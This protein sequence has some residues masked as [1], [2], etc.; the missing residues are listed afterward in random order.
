MFAEPEGHSL[1]VRRRFPQGEN[2]P[3]RP[4]I[5]AVHPVYLRIIVEKMVMVGRLGH[6]VSGPRP[7]IF[8]DQPLRVELFRLPQ[9]AD[10]LVSEAGRMAVVP[11]VV[12]VLGRALDIHV[13]GIPVPEHGHALRPPVAPDSEFRVPEPFRSAVGTQRIKGCFK[14]RMHAGVSPFCFVMPDHFMSRGALFW[15]FPPSADTF[16]GLFCF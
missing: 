5:D 2:I 4:H 12:F 1:R 16:R 13:P 9:G 11:Q 3:V 7:V 14:L 8:L 6:Q 15:V 10:I